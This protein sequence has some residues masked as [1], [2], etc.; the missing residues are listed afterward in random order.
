LSIKRGRSSAVSAT[1]IKL[2]V[3]ICTDLSRFIEMV[4]KKIQYNPHKEYLMLDLKRKLGLVSR[5]RNSIAKF[6][7]KSDDLGFGTY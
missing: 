6:D 2:A 1:A 4:T 5:I 7:L 3:I